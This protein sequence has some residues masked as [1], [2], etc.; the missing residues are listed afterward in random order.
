MN[1]S[2][3]H[4]LLEGLATNFGTEICPK[5]TETC[6]KKYLIHEKTS[7]TEC[8]CYKLLKASFKTVILAHYV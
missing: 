4:S 2:A 3:F 8:Q 6:L 7:A 1:I 5:A